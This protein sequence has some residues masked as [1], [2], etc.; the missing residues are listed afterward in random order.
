MSKKDVKENKS[1]NVE[2]TDVT[3]VKK[4]M[5][6]LAVKV[7]KLVDNAEIPTYAHSTDAGMDLKATSVEYKS[8]IDCYVYG[9]GIAVEIPE[10]YVGLVFPRSSNRKTDCYMANHVG[11]IDSGYRGEIMLS[12]K[13][14]QKNM[15]YDYKYRPQHIAV[16]Q[17]YE[18][19][20]RIGQI[21]I[22]PY[23]K[24]MFV[25]ADNLSDS[26]RGEGGHGS[27]GK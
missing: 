11:V 21:I 18:I 19:G 23:P 6:A 14:R 24:I 2:P 1:V 9:T 25:E 26:D 27:T 5:P 10:G 16:P 17:P 4:Q 3:E 22:M 15:D 7:K 13:P 8:D 20:D 12:F